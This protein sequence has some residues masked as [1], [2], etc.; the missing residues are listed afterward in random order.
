[1]RRF[2]VLLGTAVGLALAIVAG[3]M[4]DRR[5]TTRVEIRLVDAA[6]GKTT[7]AMVC[8]TDATD[9]TPAANS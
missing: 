5:G 2:L 3:A 9:G 4:A 7:P 8:I 6:T 1:M